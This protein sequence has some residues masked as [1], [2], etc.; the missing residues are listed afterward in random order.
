MFNNF[1]SENRELIKENKGSVAAALKQYL[2]DEIPNA[3]ANYN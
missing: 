1:Y 2:M 3:F